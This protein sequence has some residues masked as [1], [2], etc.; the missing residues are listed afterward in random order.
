[1]GI[2]KDKDILIFLFRCII[3]YFD[4]IIFK[5]KWIDWNS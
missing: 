2:F 3:F 4:N 1:L 5:L